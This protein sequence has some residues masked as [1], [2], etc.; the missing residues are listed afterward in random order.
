M[1]LQKK[2]SAGLAAGGMLA[3]IL[4]GQ[5]ALAGAA[6]GME[7]CLKTVIPSLLPFLFLCSVLTGALWGGN[8]SWLRPLGK[9]LGIPKGAESLLIAA[10]LGGYP[11]GAQAIGEAYREQ[12]LSWDA[13][14]HLL[15]FCSN[16]GPAFLFGMAALQFPNGQTVWALWIIQILSALL[17]GILG[18][19]G[20][21]HPALLP[22]KTASISQTLMNTVKTM[23]IICGWIL[24][25]RIFT[26][27]LTH[28]VLWYFPP[29]IQVV[30]TGLLELSNGF[31]ALSEIQDITLRFLIC[32]G[33]LSFGGLCVTMQTASVIGVLSLKPYIAGK[34]MQTVFSL[35][36]SILY[37]SCGWTAIG[38]AVLCVFIFPTGLQKR[39]RFP[40]TSGV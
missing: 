37:L 24:L 33:F 2:I 14:H 20:D 36:L 29:E 19:N 22:P 21:P 17:T 4:D 30:I 18:T 35:I 9:R 3:L 40:R 15:T 10:I 8:F 34:L 39:G 28:W 7:L 11:V 6:A 31:C 32:S 13:S 25:F 5:T 16:A 23:G 1:T 12:R 27:F 26:D 38:C